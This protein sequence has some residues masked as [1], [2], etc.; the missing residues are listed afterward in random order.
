[1]ATKKTAPA[2]KPVATTAVATRAGTSVISLQERLRSQ[3]AELNNRVAPASGITIGITQAKEF[4]FPDGTKSNQFEGVIVDFVS[5]SFFYEN[6]YDPNNIAPPACFAIGMNPLQLVPSDNSPVK[7][8]D[9]C[10]G[11]PMN[12]F[13]SSGKGKACKNGR[14]LAVLPPDADAETP[15]WL[16]KVSPT[17]LKAFDSH[18][19]SV[20][21]TFQLPPVGVV[22]TFSFD[23]GSDFAS[24]RFGNPVMN[25]NLLTHYARQ[26][27]AQQLLTSEPDVSAYVAPGPVKTAAKKSVVRR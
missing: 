11:C 3:V 18:V 8:S 5:T 2:A 24:V 21:T 13:G 27:E 22:T 10:K 15:I 7:Q 12:E 17:G 23:E 6:S 9:A 20:A 26:E 1:M 16:L 19:R 4:K 25:D 14:L